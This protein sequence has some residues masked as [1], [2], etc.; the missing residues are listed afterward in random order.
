[1]RELQFPFVKF[2]DRGKGTKGGGGSPVL[3]RVASSVAELI[4]LKLRNQRQQKIVCTLSRSKSR[5]MSD[6]E[7]VLHGRM[8]GISIRCIFSISDGETESTFCGVAEGLDFGC[9]EGG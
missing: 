1:M 2:R 8:S 5:H 6:G 7:A 4:C 3:A 9:V